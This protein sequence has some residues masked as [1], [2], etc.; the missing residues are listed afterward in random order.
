[1]TNWRE[2]KREWL[3]FLCSWDKGNLQGNTENEGNIG[4]AISTVEN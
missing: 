2:S 3:V 4:E 1:M